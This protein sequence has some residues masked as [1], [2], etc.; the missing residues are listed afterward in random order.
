MR[1]PSHLRIKQSRDYARVRGE[2]A[3]F[4]GRY[5]VLA[6]LRGVVSSGFQF[7]LIT[8]KRIGVAVVRNKVRRRLREIIRAQQKRIADG[9]HVVVI[10]R[11]R[12]PEATL[13]ALEKD[14]LRLASRAGILKPPPTHES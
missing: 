13:A 1:L 3:S 2:G 9:C 12:A 5:L 6:V 4:P 11:W 14:W 7:G 10:A 8:P